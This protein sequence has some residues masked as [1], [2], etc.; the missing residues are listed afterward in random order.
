MFAIK[1]LTLEK[2]FH[3]ISYKTNAYNSHKIRIKQHEVREK[4][5]KWPFEWQ[6]NYV[7]LTQAALS[8]FSK[9]KA[10]SVAN[11]NVDSHY[12]AIVKWPWMQMTINQLIQTIYWTPYLSVFNAQMI[13]QHKMAVGLSWM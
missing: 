3:N 8:T 9:I 7:E 11:S 2:H 5:E 1:I 12:W 10:T 13:I 6:L 4:E